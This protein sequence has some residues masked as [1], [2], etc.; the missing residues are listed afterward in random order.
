M[1]GATPNDGVSNFVEEQS[2][3]H[4]SALDYDPEH[5]NRLTDKFVNIDY[6]RLRDLPAA[7]G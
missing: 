4:D 2:V 6:D 7:K 3:I 5:F 1:Y